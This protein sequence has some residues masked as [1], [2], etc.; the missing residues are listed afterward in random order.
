V[1]CDLYETETTELADV[2]LP[3]SSWA[4]Y[5]GGYVNLEGR[6][7]QTEQAIKP[8]FESRPGYEILDL[9]AEKFDKKLFTSE[10]NRE[11]EMSQL[12]KHDRAIDLPDGYVEVKSGEI[13]T[14][15]EFPLPLFICDDPHHSGHLTEK[16]NSLVNFCGEAYIEMSSDL[17]AKF[18]LAEGDSVRVESLVGKIVVPL[19]IS[20]YIDNDVVLIP[21]NFSSTPVTSL[22]MRKRRVD[23]V[24]ISKVAD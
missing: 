7:Q 11:I 2:V 3:L 5:P 23:R 4:E 24:K 14:D 17:A 12:L 19:K 20:E 16:A 1:V 10:E 8:R 18:N 21:R 22:L 9:L 13:E 6:L 15:E